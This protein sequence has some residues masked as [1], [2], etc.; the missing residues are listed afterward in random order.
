MDHPNCRASAICPLCGKDKDRGSV[1]CWPC[2]SKHNMRRG[3]SAVVAFT[4]D[5]FERAYSERM[6]VR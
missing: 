4:L 5:T 2:Y 6:E 1:V 3:D